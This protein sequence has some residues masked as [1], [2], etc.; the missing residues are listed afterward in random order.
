M[1]Y[2]REEF[3]KLWESDDS[4]GG[5]TF[6]DCADCAKDW[7]LYSRPKCAP[8]NEV[9]YHVCQ[10]ARVREDDL[11]PSPYEEEDSCEETDDEKQEALIDELWDLQVEMEE[12]GRFDPLSEGELFAGKLKKIL[13]RF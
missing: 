10:A 12:Y 5:I 2:T 6:D 9:V 3:K 1:I 8:I 4:G 7:G 13:E 11:P